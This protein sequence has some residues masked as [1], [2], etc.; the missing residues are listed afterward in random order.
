M[1]DLV[2]IALNGVSSAGALILKV[3][4]IVVGISS[5][6]EERERREREESVKKAA[7]GQIY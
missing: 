7:R 4:G 6:Q 5:P 1:S 3:M 2:V